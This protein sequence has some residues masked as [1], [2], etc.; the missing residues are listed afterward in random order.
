MTKWPVP[1][2]GWTVDNF[3]FVDVKWIAKETGLTPSTIRRH[4]TDRNPRLVPD[5]ILP[6]GMKGHLFSRERALEWIEAYKAAP[7][8]GRRG[9]GTV[10]RNR[11]IPERTIPR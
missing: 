11:S 9:D 3:P 4:I 1:E 7:K 8:R 10:R 6:E 5:V 2:G